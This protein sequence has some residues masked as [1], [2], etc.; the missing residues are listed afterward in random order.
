M[1][2][3]ERIGDFMVRMPVCGSMW[4]PLSFIRQTLLTNSFSFMPV[5]VGTDSA[6]EWRLVSDLGLAKFLR[7]KTENQ[8]AKRLGLSLRQAI[9]SGGV[10][11]AEPYVCSPETPVVEA[12]GDSKGLPVLVVA[13]EPGQLVGIATAFDLL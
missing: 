8:R 13:G 7:G 10:I 5:N 4:Q 6:P 12:L 9:E 2:G 3:Q 11:L 1:D